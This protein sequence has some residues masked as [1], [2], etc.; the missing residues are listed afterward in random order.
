MVVPELPDA[1]SAPVGERSALKTD[2]ME[3]HIWQ[4]EVPKA[5]NSLVFCSLT[6]TGEFLIWNLPS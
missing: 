6:K 1:L 2:R 5:S 3:S 4:L